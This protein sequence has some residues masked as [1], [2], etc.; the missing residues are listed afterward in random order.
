LLRLASQPTNGENFISNKPGKLIDSSDFVTKDE[1]RMGDSSFITESRQFLSN[2]IRE[3]F[4][5]IYPG[6]PD[7]EIENLM[8]IELK[9]FDRQIT[10][11][12]IASGSNIT[13]DSGVATT[14]NRE[15]LTS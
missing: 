6:A 14:S 3:K 8:D 1:N 2:K 10:E 4:N 9:T 7:S 12:G 13:L 5:E 11:E 15:K